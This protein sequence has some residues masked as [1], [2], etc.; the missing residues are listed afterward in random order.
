MA[1]V[2][3]FKTDDIKTGE[4]KKAAFKRLPSRQENS[5]TVYV[6]GQPIKMQPY[7]TAAAAVLASEL[8][9][10]RTTPISGSARAP[11]CMMSICFECLLEIDG[12]QNVQGCMTPVK[13][14]M[15]IQRQLQAR[16]LVNDQAERAVGKAEDLSD[17][18]R[19][20]VVQFYDVS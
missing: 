15:K 17:Q 9:Y 11:Y 2:S 19:H 7:D 13:E 10:G 8:H 16:Q 4:L 5:I 14:G 12:L 18:S 3:A 6:D 1:N 20:S